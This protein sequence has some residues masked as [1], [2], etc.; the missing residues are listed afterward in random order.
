MA[1]RAHTLACLDA[2]IRLLP[3][4]TALLASHLHGRRRVVVGS[5]LNSFALECRRKRFDGF[6]ATFIGS[7]TRGDGNFADDEVD[8]AKSSVHGH[9][10]RLATSCLIE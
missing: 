6:L 10:I 2:R 8:L 1:S 5:N 4:A 3:L 9:E 7:I